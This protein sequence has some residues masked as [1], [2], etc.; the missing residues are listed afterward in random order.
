MSILDVSSISTV[1]VS[2]LPISHEVLSWI[3][4]AATMLLVQ[5]YFVQAYQYLAGKK[6]AGDFHFGAK[7]WQLAMRTVGLFYALYINDG[8]LFAVITLDMVGR[9]SEILAALHANH[10]HRQRMAATLHQH[11]A[12]VLSFESGRPQVEAA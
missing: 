8:G 7:V 5:M 6:G 12:T 10:H 9:S 4:I 1:I 11:T 2:H 3:Y